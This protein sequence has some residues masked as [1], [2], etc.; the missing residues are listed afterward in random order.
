MSVT[1]P[2]T[3]PHSTPV[4]FEATC[5]TPNPCWEF[6]RVE[7][8]RFDTTVDISIFARYDGRPCIQTVGS[9]KVPVSLPPQERGALRLRFL[10]SDGKAWEKTVMAR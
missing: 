4:Q 9:L 8:T 5:R 1:L 7:I 10:S 2:D 6:D 3:I